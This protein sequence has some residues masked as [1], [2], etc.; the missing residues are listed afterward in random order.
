MSRDIRAG[1]VET[2]S[3]K[4]R[5]RNNEGNVRK[6]NASQQPVQ[7]VILPARA[8]AGETMRFHSEEKKAVASR[9]TQ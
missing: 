9:R 3:N 1:L 6:V 7:L 2:G 4:M 5:P 8:L